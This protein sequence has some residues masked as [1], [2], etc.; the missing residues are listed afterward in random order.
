MREPEIQRR[1][2]QMVEHGLR[3]QLRSGNLLTGQLYVAIDFF[4]RA[5]HAR[6]DPA[7]TPHEIPTVTSDL[8][9]LRATLAGF[10]RKVDRFPVDEL[11]GVVGDTRDFLSKA[12]S[13]LQHADTVV[14]GLGPS[15]PTRTDLDDAVRQVARAARSLRALTDSLERHPESLIRGRK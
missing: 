3:A 4:P 13:A 15:S 2:G 5:T 6:Y 8:E 1:V 11:A 10:A 14:S 12:G 9:D 7:R